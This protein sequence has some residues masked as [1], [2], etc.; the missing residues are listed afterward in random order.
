MLMSYHPQTGGQTERLN[1]V[2]AEML[3]A[4]VAPQQGNWDQQLDM[5]ELA[6]NS[7]REHRQFTFLAELWT[8][9]AD[10]SHSSSA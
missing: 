7:A 8:G 3:R 1:R 9:A 2:I 4:C 6:Y 5:V 10:T